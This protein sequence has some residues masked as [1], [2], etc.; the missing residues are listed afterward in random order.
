MQVA[1]RRRFLQVTLAGAGLLAV[2]G[3]GLSLQATVPVAP[4]QPLRALSERGYSILVAVADRICPGGGALPSAREL[5]VAGQVDALLATLH[6]GVAAEVEQVLALLE[7][8]AFALVMDGNPRPFSAS[9]PATQDRVIEGWRTSRLSVRRQ[10]ISALKGLV[11]S[12]Y[13]ADPRTHAGVGY[14]GPP[15]GLLAM[16]RGERSVEE[17]EP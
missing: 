15:P 17:V 2:G 5:D 16:A 4:S 13:Y 8:A 9:S 7:N 12:A 11:S 1:S 3:V 10:A 14:P 6:P